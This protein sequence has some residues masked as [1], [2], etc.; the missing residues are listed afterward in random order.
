[1]MNYKTCLFFSLFLWLL[2]SCNN[3][4]TAP[5]SETINSINLKRG[6]FA[7]CGSPGNQFGSVEFETSC[8]GK[9]LNDFNLAIALLHSFEY[10]EAEKVFAKIIDE[11]PGC[12]MAYWGVAMCNYHQL[13]PSAPGPQELEKGDRAIKVAH[14]L[15]GKSQKE[16]GYIEAIAV[17]YKDY[18]KFDHRTR[19]LRYEK[20][21][22]KLHEAFPGDKEAAIFYALALDAAADP[23]DKSFTKQKKAGAILNSLYPGEPHHP[24]IV[25]YIIH[26]YDYPELAGSG[27][28]AARKYDSIAPASAHA[29][30][31]PSHIYTRL[32][33]WDEC[34]R[35][36]LAAASS[37]KC[38][39]ENTGIEGNWDEELHCLDYLVYAYLQKGE[40]KL[41][42][43]QWNYVQSVH[44]VFPVSFKAAYAFAAIPARYV[45]EN[46]MWKDAAALKLHP[47]DCPYRTHRYSKCRIKKLTYDP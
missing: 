39:A 38:Y 45:L 34:I 37:A 25:H 26:T 31:M 10:D 33:M 12:A 17:F 44:E 32:G 46:K 13:W 23:S 7:L 40:N 18:D 27:L 8:S 42:Q 22:E 41:A 20:A 2:A 47:A 28:A 11:E 43:E 3:S 30:H 29:Q 19:C 21:M 5:S 15:S 16:S 9:V 24:G 36:N 6:E 14:Q 4:N 1:M 35:S